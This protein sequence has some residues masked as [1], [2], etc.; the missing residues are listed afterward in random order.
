METS[1]GL[2]Q[3]LKQQLTLSPQLIQ[4]FEILAM[5]TL[6]LQQKIKTEIETNPALEIPDER[7]VSLERL[8][9]RQ[10]ARVDDDYGD[11]VRLSSYYDEEAADRNARFIDGALSK[12]ETLQEHLLRQL[13]CLKLDTKQMELGELLISNL[14]ENGFHRQ[15]PLSLIPESKQGQLLAMLALIQ[16]LDPPGI[17][18][19]DFRESLILQAKAD[20]L[21]ADELKT[22]SLLVE[23]HLEQMR[24][25]KNKEVSKA[26]NISEEELATLYHYLRTLNPHP[27]LQYSAAEIQVVIPDLFVHMHEGKL[28]LRLNDEAL[29]ILT[30]DK[31]FLRLQ[32]EGR[33]GISKEDSSY[34]NNVVKSANLLIS[35]ISMRSETIKKIGLQLVKHQYQFFLKGPRFL[36]PLTYRTLAEE[37]SLHETTIS[38]AVQGKYIDTDWGILP[39]KELFSS[40]VQT[41]GLAG[42]EL[43]KR[44]VMDILQEII[45]SN[46]SDK[47]LSDQKLAD[48]L[49]ERGI[50]I[51]R[52]TV[53]KYRNELNIDSSYLRP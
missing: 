47:P 19:K 33:E 37:L 48:L 3:S 9:E 50:K 31:D 30:I 4:S 11:S 53:S 34:I 51:A 42:K 39:I 38:R 27:G 41:T 5:S 45:E 28:L 10:N 8:S 25:N 17:G 35:Q 15:D 43:S 6:E 24:S 21:A 20:N 49:N 16:E 1:L 36:K 7:S 26:L 23:N 46:T 22:F 14:D 2:T 13:G 12:S 44:A 52:R 29:P 40:A 18:A 32:K